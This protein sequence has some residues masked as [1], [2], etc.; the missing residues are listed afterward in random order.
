MSLLDVFGWA[1]DAAPYVPAAMVLGGL[2]GAVYAVWLSIRA[3]REHRAQRV[4]G[5]RE[6]HPLVRRY[7]DQPD[8]LTRELAQPV[9]LH[10]REEG[11]L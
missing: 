8:E 7:H 1:L 4:A 10:A 2:V 3:A 9:D 5:R 6:Q 11:R